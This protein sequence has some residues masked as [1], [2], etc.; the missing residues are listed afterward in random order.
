MALRAK[1][2][3]ANNHGDYGSSPEILRFQ[4]WKD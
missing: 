3:G 1:I 4:P 2:Q